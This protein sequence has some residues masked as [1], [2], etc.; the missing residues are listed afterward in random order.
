M[1]TT[2][3]D[4]RGVFM[5]SESAISSPAPTPEPLPPLLVAQPRVDEFAEI[6]ADSAA[7]A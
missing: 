1:P 5:V 3:D 2:H 4:P 6:H 7:F